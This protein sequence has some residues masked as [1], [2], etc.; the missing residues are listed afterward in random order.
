MKKIL[1]YIITSII[2]MLSFASCASTD[3]SPSAEIPATV[4]NTLATESTA[5]T[6]ETQSVTTTETIS[7]ADTPLTASKQ[8]SLPNG[9]SIKELNFEGCD[10]NK[11]WG[12]ENTLL[13]TETG[14]VSV[15][16][17]ACMWS[18]ALN[19]IGIGLYNLDTEEL[20]YQTISGGVLVDQTIYFRDMD[21]G[22]YTVVVKNLGQSPIS[23]GLL[24]YCYK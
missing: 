8:V 10:G 3:G 22:T 5:E 24:R 15:S 21:A 12:D 4:F 6:E 14:T 17:N 9:L 2:V 13:T 18:P 19:E 1:A 16:I 7:A 20:H 23:Y 11:A